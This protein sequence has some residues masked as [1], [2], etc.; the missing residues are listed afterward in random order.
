MLQTVLDAVPSAIKF[1][2]MAYLRHLVT[3][4]P[5]FLLPFA[6]KAPKE[7]TRP[8]Q[9]VEH[10]YNGGFLTHHDLQC[11]HRRDRGE[12]NFYDMA[13]LKKA[14]SIEVIG[15][16]S[17]PGQGKVIGGAKVVRLEVRAVVHPPVS[18][19]KQGEREKARRRRQIAAGQLKLAA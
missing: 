5:D 6:V 2:P 3:A 15:R 16:K 8:D 4:R 12:P 9:T 19:P 17:K 10:H 14:K 11:R 13:A 1:D 7:R 18:P